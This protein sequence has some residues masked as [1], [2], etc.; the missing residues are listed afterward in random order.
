MIDT[1]SKFAV[2]V[3]TKGKTKE[4]VLSAVMEGMTK[5]GRRPKTL[6]CDRDKTFTGQ[7][8]EEQCQKENIKLIFTHTSS[9]SRT[10]Q[11]NLQKHDLEKT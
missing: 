9:S 5:M 3:K 8:F 7:L 2:V 6:Y 1:F 4:N 11:Q 10:I